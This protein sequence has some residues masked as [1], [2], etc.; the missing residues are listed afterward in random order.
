MVLYTYNTKIPS[1]S[2]PEKR[3]MPVIV[4]AVTRIM[5]EAETK[6]RAQ[7]RAWRQPAYAGAGGSE[8]TAGLARMAC[9]CYL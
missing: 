5:V 8:R 9:P 1:L 2:L 4:K 3:A 7:M 6:A